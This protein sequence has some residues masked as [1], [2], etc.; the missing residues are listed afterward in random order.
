M[1]DMQDAKNGIF[2]ITDGTDKFFIRLFK[3]AEGVMHTSWEYKV[4]E[5]DT[6]RVYGKIGKFT[7][8]GGSSIP[9]I[10]SGVL[11]VLSHTH[12][13]SDPTCTEGPTCLC[14]Y[15]GGDSLGH[16][17]ETGDNKCDV[18]GVSMT[19]K[20]SNMVIKTLADDPN[21]GVL[22]GTTDR[23]W[24]NDQFTVVVDKGTASAIDTTAN[25]YMKLRSGNTVTI[26]AKEGVMISRL[27]MTSTST[28]YADKLV[29]AFQAITGTTVAKDDTVVS[30]VFAEP[31]ATVTIKLAGTSR[32]SNVEIFYEELKV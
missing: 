25:A 9:S 16:K 11:T 1:T 20:S 6:V 7:P 18:C 21:S 26:T 23:T 13:Y 32:F 2:Y 17:D 14:G 15:V 4:V 8:S 10:Q 30:V 12:V 28:T 5:G 24:E 22:N 31:V 3:N 29:T 19:E 27:E